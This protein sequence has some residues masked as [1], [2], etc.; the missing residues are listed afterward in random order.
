[1]GLK[2]PGS[3]GSFLRTGVILPSLSFSGNLPELKHLLMIV[4]SGETS[5]GAARLRSLQETPSKD[6]IG[7]VRLGLVRLVLVRF[8]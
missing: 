6:R 7:L 5:T 3:G 1:M 2:F 8:S 4:V